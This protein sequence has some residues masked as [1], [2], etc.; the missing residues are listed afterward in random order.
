MK[1]NRHHRRYAVPVDDRP[2]TAE[3]PVLD[4]AKIETVSVLAVCG[5]LLL[6][7]GLVFGQTAVYPFVNWDDPL[8]V[9]ANPNIQ[10]GLTLASLGWAFGDRYAGSWVPLTWISHIL[11]WEVYGGRA[12]GHHLTNLVLHAATVVLLFLT[13]VR[14]TRRLWPS[15]LVAALF[16]VH[17]LRVESVAWATERK[18][19]LSG[20]FYVLT[21]AAYVSYTRRASSWPRYLTV[22]VAFAMGL[23]AKPSLVALPFLLLLLDYWPL[24]R[25]G[26]TKP[27]SSIA[28]LG[29]TTGRGF[30]PTGRGFVPARVLIEKLPLLALSAASSIVT[31]WAQGS[32]LAINEN[33]DVSWRIG[34]AFVSYLFY[35]G[36]FFCPVNLCP[37]YARLPKDFPPSEAIVACLVLLAVTILAWRWRRTRPYFLVGWLWYLGTMLPAIGLVQFGIQSVADRFTYFTQIGLAIAVAWAAADATRALLPDRG[38]QSPIKPGQDGRATPGLRGLVVGAA[39]AMLSVLMLA[40]LAVAAWRQTSYWS[41][42]VTL[43]THALACDSYKVV[44]HTSLGDAY[45]IQSRWVEAI[46]EYDEA[47]RRHPDCVEAAANRGVALRH[48]GRIDDAIGQYQSAIAIKDTPETR[49]LLAAALV[50]QRRFPEAVEQYDRSLALKDDSR[51]RAD[52]ASLLADMGRTADAVAQFEASLRLRPDDARSHFLLGS[53]LARLDRAAEAV[54]HFREAIRLEPGSAQAHYELAESL[55]NEGIAASDGALLGEAI[56]NYRAALQ[57]NPNDVVARTNLGVTLMLLRQPGEAIEQCS[58]ALA[59]RSDWAEAHNCLAVSYAQ[60][61]R[62]PEA[63][64]AAKTALKFAQQQ[65]KKD[66]VEHLHSLIPLYEAGKVPH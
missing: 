26:G 59:I 1:R 45:T 4:P 19:V 36:G 51:T 38:R 29:A 28:P 16:A 30:L 41:D 8:C 62:F 25:L 57:I 66:L 39:A 27:R 46:A 47:L 43:W 12:G 44:V 60:M 52:L 18:D 61:G 14:M 55:R 35:L 50:Q 63:L 5:L 24:G 17:P 20:F 54:P 34:N 48:M 31:M 10:K 21:L 13:L 22:I 9:Y 42:S 49:S 3:G 65:Q 58:R 15:A 7:V 23:M 6:A 56:A 32:A 40:A 11:D 2:A 37:V 33:Y 53:L 64:A